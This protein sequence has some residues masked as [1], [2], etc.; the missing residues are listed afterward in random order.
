MQKV[1]LLPVALW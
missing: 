1:H